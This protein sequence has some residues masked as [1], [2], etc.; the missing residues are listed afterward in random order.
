M[1]FALQIY[2][3]FLKIGLL[4][5]GGGYMMIPLFF[6]DLVARQQWVTHDQMFS[7]VAMAQTVPGTFAANTATLV[8]LTVGNFGYACAATLGV[9]TP[10][11]FLGYLADRYIKPYLDTP[12]LQGLLKGLSAAVIG[13]VLGTGM[14][15]MKGAVT[16]WVL[17]GVAV[18]AFYLFFVRKWNVALAMILSALIGMAAIYF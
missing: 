16:G 6:S 11:V 14:N 13:I 12:Q 10:A 5:F 3:Q 18:L 7:I 9:V 17:L 4:G 15:L 1:D 8:G 2:L